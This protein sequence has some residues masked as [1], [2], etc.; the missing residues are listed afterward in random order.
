VSAFARVI[1]Q[2]SMVKLGQRAVEQ[3]GLHMVRRTLELPLRAFEAID[4]S[5]LLAA[6]TEDIVLI[7][8]AMVG[9][10]HLCINIPIVIAC[11]AYIGWLSPVT[12]VCGVVFAAVA[13]VASV[14]LSKQGVDSLRRARAQQDA[15]VGHFR[16]LIGGFRALKLH[17]GRREAYLARSLEPTMASVRD[18][19]TRGLTSFALAEGWTQLAF[20]G[21][22]GLL[23]F[24]IPRLGPIAQSTLVSAVLVVLYLMSPLDIILTWLPILGRARA[25]L[26]KVQALIPTLER[27]GDKTGSRHVQAQPL[28]VRDSVSLE[29]VTFTYHDELED[30]GFTLGPVDLTLRRG[31]IVILAGGNG[32]G[33]TTLVK[34]LSGLY[35]PA[36][37]TLRLDGRAL[38]NADREEYRQLFSV[39]FADGHLFPNLLGLG[40]VD[41]ESRAREGLEQLGLASL[42]SVR[43]EAFSTL[44]LSQ[45]Q[46]RRLALLGARLE[47]RPIIILDEWAANQDPSFKRFFYEKLLPEWRAARKALLVISHDENQFDV[48][49]RVVRLQDGRLVDDSPLEI[50]GSWAGIRRHEIIT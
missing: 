37:G 44:D 38:G 29:G 2:V 6:L 16:T 15:L 40:P 4:T 36:A 19:T 48:A 7:A 24:V 31:E 49:D 50:G 10:P 32:S 22:I 45:G 42:V 17:R 34:L 20:F 23:L 41:V 5:A 25:S 28:A 9:I 13:I 18:E 33:K 39:V 14:Y 27:L 43:A 47:D 11:L 30:R 26:L 8:N 12:F 1:G 46:R 21:F 3:L 35:T